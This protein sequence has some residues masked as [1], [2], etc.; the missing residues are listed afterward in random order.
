[1][2]ILMLLEQDLQY[3]FFSQYCSRAK[4]HHGRPFLYF[5]ASSGGHQHTINRKPSSDVAL[6]C[7]HPK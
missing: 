7:R 6:R 4:S 5:H 2:K 3:A 1:V